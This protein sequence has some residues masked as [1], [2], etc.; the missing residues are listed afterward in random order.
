VLGALELLVHP[1]RV[2]LDAAVEGVAAGAVALDRLVLVGLVQA[3][4]TE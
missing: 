1:R 4:P 3:R 2:L